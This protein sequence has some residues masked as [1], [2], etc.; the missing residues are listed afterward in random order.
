MNTDSKMN[1]D[2]QRQAD[3]LAVAYSS[4]AVLPIRQ[5]FESATVDDAY[6]IQSFNT[7]RWVRDGRMVV[8]AK[9]GLTSIAVQKQLGVNQPD[10]G[11]LFADMAVEDGGVVEQGRLLQPKIEAEVA[12][13]MR[14]APNI[15]R[16]TTAELISSV[17][18]VLPAL[19]IVDSR[20]QGWDI[21]IIDTIAD[22][23]SSGLFVLG[24]R[25]VSIG[26]LD[27][28]RCGMVLEKNGEAVSFGAGA[29]CLGHPLHALGWL[30]RKL[31]EV[32]RPLEA[33]SIVLSGA[34]GPMI[35]VTS[36]DA[37]E[38]RIE[39]VGSVRVRFEP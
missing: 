19:E 10:F 7:D 20:I 25:P 24:T 22:N 36:G 23:A 5:E 35:E 16:L 37:F 27:L 30:A 18:Y 34:L 1:E 2:V 3:R 17:D 8:G 15:E 28:R 39:G 31:A 26:N 33:G 9:I 6:A 11:M 13:V 32:G 29:A 21:G 12:F 38:G 14:L 4:G